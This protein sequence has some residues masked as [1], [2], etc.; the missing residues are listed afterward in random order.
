[1][2]PAAGGG[3]SRLKVWRYNGKARLVARTNNGG[4]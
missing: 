4:Q 2:V 3:S 1:V